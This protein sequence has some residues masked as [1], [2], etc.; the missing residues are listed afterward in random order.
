MTGPTNA[1]IAAELDEVAELLEI[2]SA[3]P[4]RVRAYRRAART[5]R[6]HP[7][8][9]VEILRDAGERGLL[10]LEGVGESL[11]RA[12]AELAHT[13][14]LALLERLR[15]GAG[16]EEVLTTVGGIGPELARRVHEA[17][18][19]DSL[20]GLEA[21]AHDG[22]LA[23]VPGFGP[24]RVR[25]VR[26][27]LAGRFERRVQL[28]QAEHA[29]PTPVPPPPVADLLDVDREYRERAAAGTL[30]RIAP[31]R[32]NPR[33]EAWLAVLHTERAGRQYTALFSNTALAHEVGATRDWVLVVLD[34][35]DARGQWT[36]VT[37]RRGA[38]KDRRVV[39]GREAECREHYGLPARRGA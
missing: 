35:P 31:Q 33:R 4:F 14:R 27:T 23:R 38:L 37:E 5:L 19:V 32:F 16:P 9:A 34:D 18:G 20:Y 30:P 10:E 3:N 39:R 7:T 6:A 12:I 25:A 22:R 21:A 36:V 29:P 2:Q 24:G 11:A 15:S 26:E 28:L 1:S 8:S 13:G 17:L